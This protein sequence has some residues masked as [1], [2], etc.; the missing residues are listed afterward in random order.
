MW[1]LRCF[2]R[3]AGLAFAAGFG[4]DAGFAFDAALVVGLA[5]AAGLVPPSIRVPSLCYGNDIICSG[6]C[7]RELKNIQGRG[8]ELHTMK[9]WKIAARDKKTPGADVI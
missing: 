1:P 6:Y 9:K 8:G 2:A 7:I 5:V 4:F 3:A